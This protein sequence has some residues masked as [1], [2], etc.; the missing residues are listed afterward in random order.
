MDKLHNLKTFFLNLSNTRERIEQEM[1]EKEKFSLLPKE[2]APYYYINSYLEVFS[3]PH[4][5]KLDR[6]V[7]S[8]NYFKDDEG[9]NEFSERL[10]ILFNLYHIV[11]IIDKEKNGRFESWL[12]NWIIYYDSRNT[13]KTSLQGEYIHGV[14]YFSSQEKALK[15]ID[16]LI[17][18]N[19]YVT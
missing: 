5:K 2:G 15:A 14:I 4:F 17:N 6:L 9:L 10:K 3:K 8:N 13:M 18:K 11:K 16:M 12:E 19:L 7:S 1:K